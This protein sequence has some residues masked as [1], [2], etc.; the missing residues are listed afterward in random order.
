MMDERYIATIDLG[1]SKIALSV[2]KVEGA[3]L[4]VLYY[5]ER[6]SDGIRYGSIFNPTRA[7]KKIK[8]AI[9]EAQAELK[10]TIL[11]VIVS[12][13]RQPIR[14][15]VSKGKTTRSNPE[16]C[17]TQEEVDALR[18][19]EMDDY[20]LSDP[21]KEEIF[22]AVAQ[23]FSIEGYIR[24][25][26]EDIVGMTSEQFD[27][28]FRMFI[29][30][31]KQVANIDNAMNQVGVAVARKY[32]TPLA[33]GAGVLNSNE[34][35]NGVGL[36]EFGAGV[37]SLSIFE[38]G[39]LR[40][41]NAIPFGGKSIT[42]DIK[43]EANFRE[44]LAEN[45]KLAFGACQP[46]KLQNMSE[47]VL[48]IEN[49]EDGSDQELKVRYLSEIITARC[50]EIFHAILYMLKD[51]G[52][53]DKLRSGLVLTGGGANLVNCAS[54]LKELSGYKVRIGFPR[55][56]KL[57]VEGYPEIKE[58]TAA[59][60]VGMLLMS[61]KDSYINCLEEAP[62]IPEVSDIE[63]EPEESQQEE[64]E[65]TNTVF[66]EKAGK[67][68]EPVAEPAPPTPWREKKP[69]EKTPKPQKPKKEKP[70]W[71]IQKLNNAFDSLLG[72]LY[73]GMQ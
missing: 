26:E 16:S 48:R 21:I 43:Y 40:Y 63:T 47:K 56:R 1:T 7:A 69:K 44:S 12:L 67:I 57:S 70:T 53:S 3:D 35:E 32:F 8:E 38:N 46:D 59:T 49:E 33:T 55:V 61:L 45:I 68:E 62:K 41:Y 15:E 19:T 17:I 14:Q 20:P 31:R 22:A 27:C 64:V 37:T 5:K 34:I 23:S 65:I 2:A 6:P 52:Y 29:G 71:V 36:I 30:S 54:Y 25:D 4:Q 72:N 58:T 39:I 66:D 51:S 13:P 10:I 11:Q 18:S 50:K 9:E 60:T 28:N 73:D 24:A 42:N